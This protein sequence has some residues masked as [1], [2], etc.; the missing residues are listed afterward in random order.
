MKP[1]GTSEKNTGMSDA[2]LV[3]L[4]RAGSKDAFAQLYRNY[5]PL[6][7]SFVRRYTNSDQ[8]AAD[9]VQD[10]FVDALCKLDELKDPSV[11]RSWLFK[12]GFSKAI[13]ATKSYR[14]RN[15]ELDLDEPAVMQRAV[16]S[17]PLQLSPELAYEQQE[18]N[19]EL[20]RCLSQLT[21][22][23]KDTLI[24]HYYVGLSS[25]SIAQALGLSQETVRKRLH[26]ARA[27]LRPLVRAAQAGGGAGAP[28]AVT[29]GEALVARLLAENDQASARID[30]RALRQ[31]ID[32]GMCAALA[33][34]P[35]AGALDPVTAERVQAFQ[36][37]LEQGRGLTPKAHRGV[38]SAQAA[39]IAA[40]VA[41]GVLIAALGY[42]VVSRQATPP[43]ERSAVTQPASGTAKTAEAT[44]TAPATEAAAEAPV[45]APDP[46]PQAAQAQEAAVAPVAQ[47]A[48]AAPAAPAPAPAH[49]PP[50]LSVTS[51]ALSYARGTA[52][53]AAQLVADSGAVAKAADGTVLPV[54]VAGFS[55]VNVNRIGTY[56]VFL[57]ARDSQGAQALTQTLRVTIV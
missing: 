36:R 45:A 5:I 12:I 21:P 22:V 23:Q 49:Q 55:N 47:A 38:L 19:A 30:D 43:Q 28:V 15:P 50:T 32:A 51:A 57:N 37:D 29:S 48:P 7:F 4:A 54:T 24:L 56:L 3:E 9:I 44:A 25:T 27:A 16:E 10:S 11:F 26:D 33:A 42:G 46:E 17:D 13:N 39:K 2:Q 40:V 8:D 52:L 34:V 6:L 20:M 18:S 31:K 41:G 14:Q 53:T 35:V 1:G